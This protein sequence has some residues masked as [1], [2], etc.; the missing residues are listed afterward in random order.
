MTAS[1]E[2]DYAT[3]PN[4]AQEKRD[5]KKRRKAGTPRPRPAAR[6]GSAPR[7]ESGEGSGLVVRR[8]KGGL[9]LDLFLA[10][11]VPDLSR[12]RAKRLIDGKKV[13]VDG[14]I[15]PMASRILRGGERVDVDLVQDGPPA[16]PPE[17]AVLYEDS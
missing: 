4:P 17:I 8:R 16:P 6:T 9:R 15:E 10:E 7:G 1:S 5:L 14:R 2:T 11:A 3:V 12:K 13:A